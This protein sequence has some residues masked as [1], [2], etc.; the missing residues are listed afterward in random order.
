[1]YSETDVKR[2]AWHCRRGMLEL[3][4]ILARFMQDKFGS[5]DVQQQQQFEALI[6]CEDQ[7]LFAWLMGHGAPD[8]E[9]LL[10]IVQLV[11]GGA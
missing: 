11:R 10:Q 5:L 6:A 3:D 1:M 4:V 2:I 7:D 8:D 9:S